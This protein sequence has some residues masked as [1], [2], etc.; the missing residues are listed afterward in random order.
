MIEA[1]LAVC[2]VSGDPAVGTTEGNPPRMYMRA[3]VGVARM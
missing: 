3:G 2:F 1:F